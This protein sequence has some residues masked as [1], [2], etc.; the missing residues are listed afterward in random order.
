MSVSVLID[1]RQQM[2]CALPDAGQALLSTLEREARLKSIAHLTER[3]ED[4]APVM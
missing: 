4:A 2:T 1:L 3:D